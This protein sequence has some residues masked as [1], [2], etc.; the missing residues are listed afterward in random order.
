M[1]TRASLAAALTQ[2]GRRQEAVD[3]LAEGLRY[4]SPAVMVQ[5]FRSASEWR[6]TAP[7]PRL[8]LIEAYLRLGDREQARQEY[9]ALSRLDPELALVTREALG[10]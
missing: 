4:V 10:L 6:P 7:I 9:Q 8:G 5:Y 1:D 3:R 2:M